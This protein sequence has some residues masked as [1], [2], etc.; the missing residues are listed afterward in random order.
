MNRALQADWDALGP[1]AFEF[2]VLD[3]LAPPSRSDYDPSS[4]L[5]VLED[6]W[7][8]KL[9]PYDERGYNVKPKTTA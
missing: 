1:E 7:L 5:R 8:A 9:E 2:E 3:T 4:D 6:L